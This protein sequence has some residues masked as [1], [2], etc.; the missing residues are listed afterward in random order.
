ME[1]KNKITKNFDGKKSKKCCEEQI[2]I[3]RNLSE[4]TPKLN[5]VNGQKVR[6]TSISKRNTNV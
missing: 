4:R 5:T 1:E 3:K 2:T 6:S